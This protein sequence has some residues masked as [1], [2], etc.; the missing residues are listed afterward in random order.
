MLSKSERDDP[1]N[2]HNQSLTVIGNT[3]ERI[4]EVAHSRNEW[5]ETMGESQF[6]GA[7]H[8]IK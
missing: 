4:D 7:S 2:R 3:P 8:S 6:I 1:S 5:E